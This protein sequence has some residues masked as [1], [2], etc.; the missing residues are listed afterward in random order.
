MFA[1]RFF[2]GFGLI[3]GFFLSL[4]LGILIGVGTTRWEQVEYISLFF[5]SS[6]LIVILFGLVVVAIG[7]AVLGFE[8]WRFVRKYRQ[9]VDKRFEHANNISIRKV[10]TPQLPKP[11]LIDVNLEILET[12]E[13]LFYSAES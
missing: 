3:I 8:F 12:V 6:S 2:L 7:L 13:T 9:T 4:V 5:Y 11:E 10:S 1:R